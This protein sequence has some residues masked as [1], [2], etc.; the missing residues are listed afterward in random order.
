MTHCPQCQNGWGLKSDIMAVSCLM[1]NANYETW[2]DSQYIFASVLV[3]E[4]LRLH[5][6][7]EQKKRNVNITVLNVLHVI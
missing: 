6:R 3:S 7:W 4:P 2:S 5:T 1:A